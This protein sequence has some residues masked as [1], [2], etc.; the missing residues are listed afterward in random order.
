MILVAC[1]LGLV[2]SVLAQEVSPEIT[3]PEERELL[4]LALKLNHVSLA[5][6]AVAVEKLLREANFFSEQLKLP[7]PHPIQSS[8]AHI[9]VSP[10]WFNKSDSTNTSLSK[11]DRVRAATFFASGVVESGNFSFVLGGIANRRS[12]HRFKI[13]DEDSIFDLYP[14][15]SKTPS[16]IDT[17]GAYQLATQWLSAISVDVP[18]LERK[19][20]PTF[21]Q[22]F[23]WGKAED[24]PKDDRWTNPPATTNKT[25]LPIFS[26]SWGDAVSVTILGTTKELMALG[27]EGNSFVRYPPLIIT[28]AMELNTRPDPPIKHLQRRPSQESPTNSVGQT[29]SPAQRPPPFRRKASTE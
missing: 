3:D 15:L 19:N 17:N 6:R 8:D 23:F 2:R 7:T 21:D 4:G 20:K 25:L 12:I 18:A 14:E 24:L 26:V 27:M 28:N 16:L 29:N 10:P 9:W 1:F 13:K 5:Y 22:R 11:A